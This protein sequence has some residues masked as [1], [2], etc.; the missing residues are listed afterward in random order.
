M[1]GEVRLDDGKYGQMAF[2][3]QQNR[4]SQV[5]GCLRKKFCSLNEWCGRIIP[6]NLAVIWE[7][8]VKALEIA[9]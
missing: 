8:P 7:I 3:T 1:T 4:N 5:I 9:G 6:P 2:R